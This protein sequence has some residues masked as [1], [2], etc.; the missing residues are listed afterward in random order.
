MEGR[1]IPD[2]SSSLTREA[3]VKRGGALVNDWVAK[4]SLR[5]S[6]WP[7]LRTGRVLSSLVSSWWSSF[8]S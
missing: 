4:V 2:F 8:S 6:G 1:P 3:S 5:W 7:S